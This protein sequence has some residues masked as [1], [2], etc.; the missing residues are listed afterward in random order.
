MKTI[1]SAIFAF[2][3]CSIVAL[4]VTFIPV[5]KGSAEEM[6]SPLAAVRQGLQIIND[7]IARKQL[8]PSWAADLTHVNVSIRNI[9][10][11]SEYVVK[12]TRSTGTPHEMSIYLHTTGGFSGSSL[13]NEVVP[14]EG[15][16][17]S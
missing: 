14:G 17:G 7:L 13:N 15:A 12:V 1:S 10:D 9:K 2:V 5:T 4:S 3:L 11:F 16:S 8:D 6:I